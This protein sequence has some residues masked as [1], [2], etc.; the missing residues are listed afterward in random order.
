[1]KSCGSRRKTAFPAAATILLGEG[2]RIGDGPMRG[3]GKSKIPARAKLPFFG[4]PTSTTYH[5]TIGFHRFPLFFRE[6]FENS[7]DLYRKF[8]G[9][10]HKLLFAGLLGKSFSLKV[11]RAQRG[12]ITRRRNARTMPEKRPPEPATRLSGR[13]RFWRIREWRRNSVNIGT[14]GLRL[15]K[16]SRDFPAYKREKAEFSRNFTPVNLWINLWKMWT[17]S[18]FPQAGGGYFAEL[19][20]PAFRKS[21]PQSP[22]KRFLPADKQYFSAGP[23]GAIPRGLVKLPLISK[24]FPKN[25]CFSPQICCILFVNVVY[26]SFVR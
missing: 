5:S 23:A 3:P 6:R 2:C 19:C 16:F 22:L 1:M 12:H 15:W 17:T 14:G 4:T 21:P 11:P 24:A 7:V 26:F 18:I 13:L 20:L 8:F 25:I 10:F 9:S